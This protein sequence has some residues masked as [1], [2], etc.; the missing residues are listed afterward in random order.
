MA[1][2][3]WKFYF[4]NGSW[5]VLFFAIIYFTWV[6]TKGL[7]LEEIGVKFEGEVAIQGVVV[8][9]RG[10]SV[11]NASGRVVGGEIKKSDGIV[12]SVQ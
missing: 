5:V 8:D 4:I 10:S 7:T 2:L 11:E 12:V 1:D 6:E 9:E 3:G